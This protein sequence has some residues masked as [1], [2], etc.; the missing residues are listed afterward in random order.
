MALFAAYYQNRRT[1]EIQIEGKL[2]VKRIDAY[3]KLLYC[4]YYGQDFHEVL[5]R[6]LETVEKFP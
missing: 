4:L 3:E 5:L 2:A 6:N 1:R